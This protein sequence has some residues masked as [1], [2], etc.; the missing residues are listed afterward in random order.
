MSDYSCSL[1][2]RLA[3]ASK[4]FMYLEGLLKFFKKIRFIFY[5]IYPSSHISIQTNNTSTKTTTIKGY[6]QPGN[7]KTQ[8][9][10]QKETINK[11]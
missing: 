2:L 8:H 11:Q 7:E 5:T 4:H 1:K 10:E 3:G 9:S 6:K